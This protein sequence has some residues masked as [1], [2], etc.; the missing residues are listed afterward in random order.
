MI[1]LY[2]AAI[3]QDNKSKLRFRSVTAIGFLQG[4]RGTAFTLQ[5]VNGMEKDRWFA[6]L[7]LALDYYHTRSFPIFMQIRRSFFRGKTPFIYANGGVN[8]PWVHEDF[9]WERNYQS[10]GYAEG[11]LGYLLPL[12]NFS[13]HFAAGYSYKSFGYIES[14]PVNCLIPPCPEFEYTYQY[15]LNRLAFRVG[16]GF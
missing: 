12:K 11:G 9:E 7:G 5:S 15:R 1:T 8:I 14:I 2:G 3:A 6:G 10:G 4:E 16:I 13:I